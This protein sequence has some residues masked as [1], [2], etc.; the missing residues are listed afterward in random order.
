MLN[1]KKIKKEQLL[2]GMN[3]ALHNSRSLLREANL[4]IKYKAYERALA[5]TVLSLEE[6][7]KVV[8][9][10][11]CYHK[12]R[13]S[14]PQKN[15]SLYLNLYKNHDAKIS[16]FN[17]YYG[18]RWK[19]W[20]YHRKRKHIKKKDRAIIALIKA[21][22]DVYDYLSK[23]GLSSITELKLKCFYT[24]ICT[25]KKNLHLPYK[26][27]T[28]VVKGLML[29]AKNH[30]K[31]AEQL[32]N[33]FRRAKTSDII[34]ELSM[35]MLRKLELKKLNKELDEIEKSKNNNQHH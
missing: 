12:D 11:L 33:T 3:L 8:F 6:T 29:L 1:I 9:L 35:F 19:L 28:K 31:D 20:L 17:G 14:A 7:G 13:H 16:F 26:P 15:I 25:D 21:R 4:L 18:S 10:M 30:I 22:T 2:K 34:E 24:D 32:R 5:L 23:M 27:P